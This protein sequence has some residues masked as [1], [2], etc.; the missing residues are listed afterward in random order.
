MKL[1]Q[2][3]YDDN[4]LRVIKDW[5]DQIPSKDTTALFHIYVP[6]NKESLR[7]KLEEVRLIIRLMPVQFL[8]LAAQPPVRYLMVRCWMIR[9]SLL[10]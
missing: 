4:F 2:T 3:V 6:Y 5:M 9:W 7:K 10:L 1:L 8:L